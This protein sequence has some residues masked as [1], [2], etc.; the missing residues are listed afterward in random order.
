VRDI[1]RHIT[2]DPVIRHGLARTTPESIL[3]I[4]SD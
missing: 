3:I 4:H 1:D 2:A